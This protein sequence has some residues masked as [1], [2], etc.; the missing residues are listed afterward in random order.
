MRLAPDDAAGGVTV[1]P[2]SAAPTPRVATP[3]PDFTPRPPPT[4]SAPTASPGERAWASQTWL[5]LTA[6]QSHNVSVIDPRSGHVLREVPVDGDQAGM[7]VAPGGTRLYIVD[8]GSEGELRI[9]DTKDW[10]VVHRESIEDRALLLGGNP[11]ALS[12]DGRWLVVARLNGTTRHG[13][14]GVFDTEQMHFLPGDPL[15]LQN[16]REAWLPVSLV[17]RTGHERVYAA[18]NGFIMALDTNTLEKV[19]EVS[20]PTAVKGA[21]Q[22]A[23]DGRYLYGLYPR[24]GDLRLHVW[25]TRNG[26]AMREALLGDRISIPMPTPGRGE[27]GYLAISP[28]GERLYIAWED[29]LW[30]LNSGSLQPD[31]S[32]KLPAAID[33]LAISGDGE[34]LYLLP[35]T[36]GDLA[37]RERGLWTVDANSLRLLRHADDWPTWVVPFFFAVPAAPS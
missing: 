15:A 14:T 20:A 13:W 10:Q 33:G 12:G 19:W 35:A 4:L 11:I 27:G 36:A 8:G 6:F 37:V 30:S 1:A 34:E 26:A 2:V 32:L 31:G 29:R 23:P 24:V 7:D 28:D 21:L 16:C 5:Y 25:D 9:Y 17:G 3:A 18:C 22:L